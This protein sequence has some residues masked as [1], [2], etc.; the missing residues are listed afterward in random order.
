VIRT[1]QKYPA[2]NQE[3]KTKETRMSHYYDKDDAKHRMDMAKA[4]PPEFQAWMAFNNIVGIETGAIP[5]KYRELIAIAVAHATACPYCMESHVKKG[6]AAGASK[7][8]VSEAILIAAALCAG[9]AT[10][11]GGM[12]MKFYDQA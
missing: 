2:G 1:E 7:E 12:S 3:L 5:L 8:E 10:A 6:K 4:A 9:A 11:H